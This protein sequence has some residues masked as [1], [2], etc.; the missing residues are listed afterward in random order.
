MQDTYLIKL[1]ACDAELQDIEDNLKQECPELVN[2]Q[3][4]MDIRAYLNEV[5]NEA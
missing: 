3:S 5:I 4:V 2:L 1:L